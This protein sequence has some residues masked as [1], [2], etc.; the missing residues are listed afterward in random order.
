MCIDQV[1][2]IRDEPRT[3]T[4]RTRQHTLVTA[5]QFTNSSVSE[6]EVMSK[7]SAAMSGINREDDWMGLEPERTLLEVETSS[8]Y[9]PHFS[10][11]N[12]AT[13]DWRGEG[14]WFSF[15]SWP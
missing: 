1:Y 4:A 14:G 12:K 11:V 7:A 2:A 10:Q 5:Y 6:D 8:N 9:F 3:R 15:R 13:V